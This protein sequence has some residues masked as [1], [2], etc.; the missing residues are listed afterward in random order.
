M[1]NGH[2][3]IDNLENECLKGLYKH[4]TV[5]ISKGPVDKQGSCKN[6]GCSVNKLYTCILPEKQYY[7]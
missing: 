5:S 4:R 1:G 7:R 3:Y 2:G 6:T